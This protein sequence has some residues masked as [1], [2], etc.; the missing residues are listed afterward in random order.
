MDR[1]LS[2]GTVYPADDGFVAEALGTD[3]EPLDAMVLGHEPTF[4]GSG[5]EARPIGLV[6][7]ASPGG[8]EAKI[9]AGP[10]VDPA[11]TD[12]RETDDL[13]DDRRDEVARFFDVYAALEPGS[14]L[15]ADGEEGRA[16]ALA[17]IADARR[18]HW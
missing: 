18:R 4:R 8:R 16:A 15:R 6:W 12:V 2:S 17:V 13:G 9:L 1:R 3:G 14:S 10:D 11:W 7:L 5:S